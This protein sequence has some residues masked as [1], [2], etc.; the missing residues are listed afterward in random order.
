[1]RTL[2]T[3]TL[4]LVWLIAG[5]VIVPDE[6]TERLSRLVLKPVEGVWHISDGA[7]MV[8]ERGYASGGD[9]VVTLLQSPDL[10]MPT[11]VVIGCVKAKQSGEYE[12]NVYTKFRNGHLSD[13][14]KFRL[15]VAD[16]RLSLS[17]SSWLP[18]V[19]LSFLLHGLGPAIG[20]SKVVRPGDADIV[21]RRIVPKPAPSAENPIAL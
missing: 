2:T 12:L 15:Q 3:F 5:A 7:T 13:R 18:R 14:T 8:I 20:L 10:S 1:M 4:L 9:Y 11:P 19:R 17:N 21:A 16:D 6:V